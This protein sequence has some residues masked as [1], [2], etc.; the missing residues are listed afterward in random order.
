MTALP[1]P[2]SPPSDPLLLYGQAFGSRLM[3]GTARYPSPA[4]LEQAVLRASPCMLT[5]SLRRQGALGLDASHGFWTLLQRLGVPVLPNTACT[6][7]SA[8]CL[9]ISFITRVR[10]FNSSVVG[11]VPFW[12]RL[13]VI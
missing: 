1:T 9:P 3:L 5:A 11:G 6:P 2:A 10:F 8:V 4:V 13:L 12:R 7:M